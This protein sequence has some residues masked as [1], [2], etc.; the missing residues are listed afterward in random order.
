[1]DS[2][3]DIEIQHPRLENHSHHGLRRNQSRRQEQVVCLHRWVTGL[4]SR[5]T[6]NPIEKVEQKTAGVT[7]LNAQINQV[8]EEV[9]KQ[10]QE[11]ANN[12][13]AAFWNLPFAFFVHSIS[14]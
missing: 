4:L 14:L 7:P 3:K 11:G 6:S 9:K 5:N 2:A 10:A 13:T 8:A 1:V 12:E